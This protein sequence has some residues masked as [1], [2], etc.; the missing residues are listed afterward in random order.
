MGIPNSD[1]P[2]GHFFG[3]DPAAY[4]GT[5]A[6]AGSEG[7][8]AVLDTGTP[9]ASPIVTV[10]GWTSQGPQPSLQVLSSSTEVPSAASEYAKKERISG[11]GLNVGGQGADSV[12]FGQAALDKNQVLFHPNSL[13][14][15]RRP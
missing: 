5:G 11:V 8:G 14:V 13:G 2:V 4:Y 9:L 12:Q 10:P 15:G 7:I 3:L 1:G 6:G